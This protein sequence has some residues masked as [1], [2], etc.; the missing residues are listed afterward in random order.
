MKKEIHYVFSIGYRCYSPDFLKYYNLRML[1]GPFDYLFIDIETSFQNINNGFEIFL[2][3]IVCLNKNNNSITMHYSS[4]KIKNEIV[5]FKSYD[6]IGYMSHNYNHLD[7][8]INQNFIENISNN[9]YEWDRICVFHHH[10]MLDKSTYDA[11]TNRCNTFKK[12]YKANTN[13]L[14]LLF[15]T[16]IVEIDEFKAYKEYIYNLKKKYK[17]NSYIIIIICSDRLDEIECFENNILFIVKR[18]NDYNYQYSNGIG[19]D[20]NLNYEKEKNIILQ[21][22]DFK[23]KT[24]DE[25]KSIP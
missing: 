10:N 12:I 15:I 6:N 9:L 22:F 14:C 2:N 20:N 17:I 11:L 18:V 19:T 21:Y 13:K 7:L 1:S 8:R 4:E 25:I 3:D 24:Y 5:K 16:K 23:L